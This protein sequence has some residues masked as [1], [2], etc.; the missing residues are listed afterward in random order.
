[1]IPGTLAFQ[2][3]KEV[4]KGCKD[5]LAREGFPD[6]EVAFRES[7]V[8]QSVD[9][10]FLSFDPSVD[11]F[12]ELRST[13]TPTLGIRIASLKTPHLEGTG[14]VYPRESSESDRVFFSPPTT[15]LAHF[16][17]TI[18]SSYHARTTTSLVRI[19]SFLVPVPT[20]MSSIV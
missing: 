11:P 1:M 3:A 8:T 12:P 5:I 16:P 15:S 18:T 10:K 19:S 2:T 13:F 14:A 20:P 7:T 4:A 9:P 6:V 17:Y